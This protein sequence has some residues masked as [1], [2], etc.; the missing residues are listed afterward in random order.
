M[1]D[2]GEKIPKAEVGA[3]P[4]GT[5]KEKIHYPWLDINKDIGLDESDAGKTI[6]AKVKLYVKEVSKRVDSQAGEK[7]KK[8]ERATFDVLAISIDKGEF[9]KVM[10]EGVKK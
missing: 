8:T 5:Q 6:T 3:A 10:E 9:A 1:I 4:A 2:L 7:T